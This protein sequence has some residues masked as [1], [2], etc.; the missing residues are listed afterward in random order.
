[1]NANISDV[2]AW[3]PV[4]DRMGTERQRNVCHSG[5]RGCLVSSDLAEA[6]QGGGEEVEP[7]ETECTV[8]MSPLDGRA[9][10][11]HVTWGPWPQLSVPFSASVAYARCLGWSRRLTLRVKVRE[12]ESQTRSVSRCQ[13]PASASTARA[14]RGGGGGV[15][16][17]TDP[18]FQWLLLKL[19][20]G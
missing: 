11:T 14:G 19:R 15:S 3:L 2:T 4:E 16:F 20:I 6:D 10:L 12:E 5:F 18:S 8:K 17:F 7:T 9:S 13:R 1:M